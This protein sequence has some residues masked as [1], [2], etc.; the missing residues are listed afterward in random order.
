MEYFAAMSEQITATYNIEESDKWNIE[1]K[2]PDIKEHLLYD[3]IY[4]NFESR[5]TV[6]E[7]RILVVF[8]EENGNHFGEVVSGYNWYSISWSGQSVTYGNDSLS[9]TVA[10]CAFSLC[11]L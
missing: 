2:E 1:Q 9:C 5:S 8:G 3:S 11:I 10:L 6:F 4:I 7:F